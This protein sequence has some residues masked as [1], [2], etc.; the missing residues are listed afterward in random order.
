MSVSDYINIRDNCLYLRDFFIGGDNVKYPSSLAMGTARVSYRQYNEQEKDFYTVS[1]DVRSYLSVFDAEDTEK[2]R[3]RTLNS[4][5]FN[6][7][8]QVINA[9]ADSTTSKVSRDL[10]ELEPFVNNNVDYRDN[11]WAE[12]INENAKMTALYGMTATYIDYT[13]PEGAVV[14]SRNDLIKQGITPKAVLVNPLSFAW[15]LT[16]PYGEVE[17]FAWFENIVQDSNI[18]YNYNNVILRIVNKQGWR[19]VSAQVNMSVSLYQQ[20]VEN[21]NTS[22]MTEGKHPA[23]LNGKIPVVFNYYN[24]DYGQPYPL[25][26]SLVVDV[27]DTARAV[28]NYCSWASDVHQRSAFPILTIPLAKSGGVMPPKT[29][30][31]VGSNNALP[32]D[33]ESGTPAFIAAPSDPTKELREHVSF[34]INKSY[35]LLGLS[36]VNDSSAAPSSGEA[37][38]IRS[39]EFESY[40]SKFAAHMKKYEQ[41]TLDIFKAYL[42]M[43]DVETNIIYPKTFSIPQTTE[44]IVNAQ[45]L[46]SIPFLSNEGKV[47][48]LRQIAS[49]ALSASDDELNIIVDSSEAVLISQ[50][51]PVVAAPVDAPTAVILP[52]QSIPVA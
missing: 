6:I 49:V 13:M 5:Y 41:K 11:T 14:N 29:E 32:Y 44:D 45:S 22:I 7:V 36:L 35:Q 51:A 9:Y 10:G 24:R 28:Y 18:G 25:G 39:R 43:E 31:A 26:R 33:S 48:A 52:E 47:A 12:F 1:R 15:V 3:Q 38:K 4:Y 27:V 50:S 37:L 16:N 19:Q 30:I 17:E 20:V 8:A 40:A 2:F 21:N 46:L 34:M 42:G 23:S